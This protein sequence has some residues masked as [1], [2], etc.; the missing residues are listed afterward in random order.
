MEAYKKQVYKTRA[1]REVRQA[2]ISRD[3]DICFFC[4]KIILKRRT[5]HHKNEIN[6]SNFSD[7][8][9]AFNLENLVECHA[10]CHNLHHDRF[11]YS[12]K[13]I[14]DDDLEID[15]SKRKED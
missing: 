6:E 14:V 10:E 3:R 13:S 11:G 2:V 5:I 12:K 1:W 9:V 8:E 7:W 15:Y 4:G